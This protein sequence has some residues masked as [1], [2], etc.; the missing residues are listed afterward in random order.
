MAIADAMF[1]TA[2]DCQKRADELLEA[3]QL[4]S[5]IILPQLYKQQKPKSGSLFVTSIGVYG[6][7]FI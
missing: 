2:A 3:S 1:E 5:L 7:V 4:V 6:C